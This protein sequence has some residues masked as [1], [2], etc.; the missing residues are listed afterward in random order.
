MVC[1]LAKKVIFGSNFF[2]NWSNG[3]YLAKMGCI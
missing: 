3:L 2:F 1:I